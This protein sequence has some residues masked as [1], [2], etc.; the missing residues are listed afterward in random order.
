MPPQTS[1]T[2]PTSVIPA[3]DVDLNDLD[4]EIDDRATVHSRLEANVEAPRPDLERAERLTSDA[5][6][7]AARYEHR[8][9]VVAPLL[10]LLALGLL[11]AAGWSC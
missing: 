11:F 7:E 3:I 5:A 1:P 6:D 10:M 9:R 2:P 4:P 8:Q